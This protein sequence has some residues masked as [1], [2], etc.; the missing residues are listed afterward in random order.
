MP[1][2]FENQDTSQ[3]KEKK[4]T[5]HHSKRQRN[6]DNRILDIMWS[7][8]RKG[9]KTLYQEVDKTSNIMLLCKM[10]MTSLISTDH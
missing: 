7:N 1:G 8:I 3:A 2:Y 6:N 5:L 4:Q 9:N 10:T